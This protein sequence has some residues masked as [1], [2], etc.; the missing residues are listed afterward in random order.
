MD[1]RT[2]NALQGSIKKWEAIRD[3][4]CDDE[5]TASCPLCQKFFDRTNCT[6]CPVKGKTG[7]PCCYGTP[8]WDYREFQE[9]YEHN[10]DDRLSMATD[11]EIIEKRRRLAQAEVDF[12][13]SLL[14]EGDEEVDNVEWNIEDIK[15]L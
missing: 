2:Y 1:E 15:E 11:S 9:E 10:M 13:I 5:G 3:G 8:Y 7:K 4:H 14:P 12:L 6:D